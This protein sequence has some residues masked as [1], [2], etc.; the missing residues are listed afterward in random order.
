MNAD[1]TERKRAAQTLQEQN[2]RTALLN[3]VAQV[4]I[5]SRTPEEMADSLVAVIREVVPCDA[6]FVDAFDEANLLA[7]A[8]RSYDTMEGVFRSV[9]AQ[10]VSI[11]P[12]ASIHSKVFFQRK[13]ERILR[14][15]EPQKGLEMAAFGDTSRRSASLL[16]AP[17]AARN[18]VVGSISVQSYTQ[19]AYSEKEEFLL[20]AI[21]LQAGPA[22][23]AVQLFSETKRAEE[24]LRASQQIIEGILNAIP[25]RVF[26]KD[27]N[28]VFL[29]CNAIFARDAGFADPKEI[30]G[31]DDYQMVWRDQAELYRGDDRQI[32]ESGG[33][34]LFIE[35]TQTTPEG[36]TIT[37]LTSK[38]PLRNSEGEIS[39]IL[40][41]YMDITERKK[42]EQALQEQ[43]ER[44]A[45]LN[46]VAQATAESRTPEE[47][48]DS[49]IAVLREVMPCDAS[50][51]NS[52]DEA[53]LVSRGI[54]IY[55]MIDGVFRSVA[56]QDVS[57]DPRGSIDPIIY[58][59]RKPVRILRAEEPQKG[60]EMA[61]FGDTSRRSASLLF[62]PMIARNKVVGSIS[63]QSYTHNAYSEKEENLLFEIA[64]QAGPAF[65]AVQLYSATK[66]AEE[67]LRESEGRV[68]AKLD[69]ILLPEGDIG[70]L[71]L[72]DIIDIPA[73]QRLMDNFF[74]LT[75]IGVAFLDLQGKVLVATGWQDICTKF[76]R[77]HP[78]TAQYCIESDTLLSEN[79][80]PGDI[81]NLQLQKQY[82]GYCNSYY[83]RRKTCRQS[84]PG[85]VPL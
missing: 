2:E 1:I 54:R 73:I 26:W 76:H 40:G 63:V 83:C 46:R 80:E 82:E 38:M 8:I 49:L 35:E 52:F 3:R 58:F 18:K 44:T 65:E 68:R 81:Q 71:E 75:H 45:L 32:I 13:S 27:R 4:T 74:H 57:M 41:T 69:A 72:A 59:Q 19:N 14:T 12:R 66:R 24:A 20:S 42:V 11:D 56:A 77:I 31:K 51:V 25:V 39:G 30:I 43:N 28:L 85:S 64:R 5:E 23:E 33:S 21:A 16:F 22:F 84:F 29:G 70:A 7:R 34:K 79:V 67:A 48:A 6:F 55:D 17:M 10:D 60:L 61:A 78:E 47:M 9:A 53:N 50:Y 15:E 37:L 62:A 36:K